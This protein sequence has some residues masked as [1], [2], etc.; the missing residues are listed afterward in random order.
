MD[1]S[2][3]VPGR[4]HAGLRAYW[5]FCYPSTKG[6]DP[7]FPHTPEIPP[8]TLSNHES[9]MVHRKNLGEFADMGEYRE[10]LFAAL[11]MLQDP[12]AVEAQTLTRMCEE[13]ND[14]Y[15][16]NPGLIPTQASFLVSVEQ[17]REYWE[18]RAEALLILGSI[19]RRDG[20]EQ[21]GTEESIAYALRH[22]AAH[23]D[24]FIT[25]RTELFDAVPVFLA[26]MSALLEQLGE[27]STLPLWR[28]KLL[29]GMVQSHLEHR[30][31]L[32][33]SV[34]QLAN[35]VFGQ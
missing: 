24:E 34:I 25:I 11:A 23:R 7:L 14:L 19:A 35:R 8:T 29:Q 10:A 32:Q 2:K 28:V 31:E 18:M 16:S 33:K 4:E 20:A 30:D 21:A 1:R 13:L 22:A 12:P 6:K 15:D 26:G 9:I 3:D 5:E 17:L 27:S